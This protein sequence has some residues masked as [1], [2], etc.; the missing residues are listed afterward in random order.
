MIRIILLV[1]IAATLTTAPR[2]AVA[3]Y[4]PGVLHEH[5]P[6][7]GCKVLWYKDRNKSEVKTLR[8]QL[9]AQGY[10]LYF[11]GHCWLKPG[12]TYRK[13]PCA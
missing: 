6:H 11:D 4:K 7:L 9:R 3:H 13:N 1:A 8:A 12:H 10:R 2:L 5:V